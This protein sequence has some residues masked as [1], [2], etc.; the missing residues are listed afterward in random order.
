MSPFSLAAWFPLHQFAV[1]PAC[2]FGET[3]WKAQQ[4]SRISNLVRVISRNFMYCQTLGIFEQSYQV[5]V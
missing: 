5:L 1:W 3:T 2:C 4:K